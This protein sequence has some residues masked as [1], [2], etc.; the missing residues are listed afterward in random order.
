[1]IIGS[2]LLVPRRLN[3]PA[4]DIFLGGDPEI[5]AIH[6]GEQSLE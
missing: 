4:A 3:G 1:L 6:E 5:G 2:L